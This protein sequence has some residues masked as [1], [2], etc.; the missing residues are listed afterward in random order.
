MARLG[1]QVDYFDMVEKN[2]IR[3]HFSEDQR[4]R[5]TLTMK[6]REELMH[7]RGDAGVTVI[8]KNPSS[9]DERRSDSTIRKVE[10]FVWQRFQDVA[11]LNILNIF[12]FRA[13][14]A[15]ELDLLL[16]SE[17]YDAAIG[18]DNDFHFKSVLERSQRSGIRED[19][20]K[21]RV[22]EVR[23]LIRNHYRGSVYQVSGGSQTLEPLHG[24]MWG[25]HYQLMPYEP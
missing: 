13:T 3:A 22:E 21:R 23:S 25:Y 2:S 20:Y 19:L 12:A 10:T 16:K 8:L 11:H 6:Y 4:H 1:R 5:Y 24:L 15:R 17:G 7:P 18:S 9:A 14:D